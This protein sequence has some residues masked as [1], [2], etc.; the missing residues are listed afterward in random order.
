MNWESH[1]LQVT[2]HN[3][4][5]ETV[6]TE[7]QA[8]FCPLCYP[9]TANSRDFNNYQNWYTYEANTS[10]YSGETQTI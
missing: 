5:H 2:A 7:I 8:R 3:K 4:L 6:G 10:T 9:T 1:Q